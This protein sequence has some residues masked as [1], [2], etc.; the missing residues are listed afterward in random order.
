MDLG[1][2]RGGKMNRGEKEKALT[3]SSFGTTGEEELRRVGDE[4]ERIAM[5]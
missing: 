3:K 1:Q 4:G 2:T 5:Q